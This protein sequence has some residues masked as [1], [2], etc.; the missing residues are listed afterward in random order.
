[1]TNEIGEIIKSKLADLS[2]IEKLA[3]VVKIMNTTAMD[4][5]NRSVRKSFPIACNMTY[6]DCSV[7]GMYMDLVPNSKVKS[8][9]YLEDQGIR[10]LNNNG[11]NK[12]YQATYLLVGWLNL[13]K[14]G[15]TDCSGSGKAVANILR[16]LDLKPFNS[17]IY[18][19]IQIEDLGQNAASN[20]PFAKYTYDEDKTQYLMY[21]YDYFSIPLQVTFEINTST[22]IDDFPTNEE[23]PC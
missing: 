15:I 8:I 9:V 7:K 16:V 3:G 5:N 2:F 17:G 1:M 4:A 22:C 20:N 18:L 21:P 10:K 11:A 19:K 14:L 12:V 6:E 23:L 13:K